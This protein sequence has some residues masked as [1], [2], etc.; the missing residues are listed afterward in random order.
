MFKVSLVIR[1]G[2]LLF[3]LASLVAQLVKNSP[4]M[5]ETLVW[6]LSRENPPEEGMATYS[7]I[8]GKDVYKNKKSIL[9]QEKSFAWSEENALLL[10]VI[11]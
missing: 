4:A 10:L 7:S 9:Y 3:I 8:L 5:Q 1:T 6:F 2:K 11:C